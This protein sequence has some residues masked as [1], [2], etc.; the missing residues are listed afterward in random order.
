MATQVRF[1]NITA[2][3]DDHLSSSMKGGGRGNSRMELVTKMMTSLV[4]VVGWKGGSR[5]S[6]R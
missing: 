4:V 6:G 3:M 1:E 2:R 5:L